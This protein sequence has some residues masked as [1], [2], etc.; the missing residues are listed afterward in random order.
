TIEKFA[1]KE[2]EKAHPVLTT[3][4]N[5]I[6]IADEA[7][8]TQYGLSASMTR[9]KEGKLRLSQGF[10]L[11]LRQALPNAAYLGFTGTPIDKEDAD[12]IQIFGDYIH[13]YD[14]QQARDDKA[15]VQILY[16]ARHI[17]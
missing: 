14:M 15:V 10:A 1:L 8:R 7:H 5:L 17:P 13:I 2:G 4:H 6:V 11:N 16:E 9:D 12:T 3:R